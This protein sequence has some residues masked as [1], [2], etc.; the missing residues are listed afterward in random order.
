MAKI[1]ALSFTATGRDDL[2]YQSNPIWYFGELVV[3]ALCASPNITQLEV[4]WLGDEPGGDSA[5]LV[6]AVP[7]VG[8]RDLRFFGAP[9]G[10]DGVIALASSPIIK[11]LRRLSLDDSEIGDAG[12]LALAHGSQLEELSIRGHRIGPAAAAALRAMPSLKH[13]DFAANV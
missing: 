10:D 2:N 3:A 4:L 7:F 12:A 6:A 1:R 5:K 8:L 11:T 13:I 9:I